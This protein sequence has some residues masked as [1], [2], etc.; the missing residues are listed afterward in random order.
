MT[1]KKPLSKA[2]QY[3]F[4]LTLSIN[5]DYARKIG[6]PKKGIATLIVITD[7]KTSNTITKDSNNKEIYIE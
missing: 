6:K 2:H 4:T 1:I 3:N 5:N 7:Q